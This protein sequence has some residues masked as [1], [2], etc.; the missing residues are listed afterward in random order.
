MTPDVHLVRA[1]VRLDLD[2]EDLSPE[3]QDVVGRYLD[4][5]Y[6]NTEGMNIAIVA[7]RGHAGDDW[8]AYIGAQPGRV[9]EGEVVIWTA[10]HD[11]KI[12]GDRA[13]GWFGMRGAPWGLEYREP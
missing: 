5:S 6:Y 1:A 10:R 8:A 12:A 4:H 11:A 7:L 3:Q 13:L 9:R 2:V